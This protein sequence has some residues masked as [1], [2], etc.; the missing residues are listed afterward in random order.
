[1][2]RVGRILRRPWYK[3]WRAVER[4]FY[5]GREYTLQVPFGQ[6]VYTPWFGQGGE[7]TFAQ[8]MTRVRASGP[9]GVSVDRCHLLYQLSQWSLRV[10]G[11]FAECGVFTGG[12]AHLLAIV[13]SGEES[14]DR[15]PLHLFDTFTGMPELARPARDYHGPG[16]FS[17]TSVEAVEAR[18]DYPSCQFHPGVMPGTFSDVSDVESY[19]FVHIDVDIYDSAMECCRWF[20]PRMTKGGIMVFDDYGFY[21]YRRAARAAVDTYFSQQPIQPVILPTGQAFVVNLH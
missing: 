13:L 11:A 17:G 10:A 8:A 6:R 1:V 12:T 5:Q 20:W 9:V 14:G 7:S 15:R 19:A 2:S 18:L 4:I 3:M 16:D 21:P